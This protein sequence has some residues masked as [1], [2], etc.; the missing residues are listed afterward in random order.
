M[1]VQARYQ[2]SNTSLDA[3]DP[4]NFKKMLKKTGVTKE[5]VIEAATALKGLRKPLSQLSSLSA[6]EFT[7]S[8]LGQAL[9]TDP[10]WKYLTG[11]QSPNAKSAPREQDE[12][13]FFLLIFKFMK[14]DHT[15][16]MQ[17]QLA[18]MSSMVVQSHFLDQMT[19]QA[20]TNMQ[21]MDTDIKNA[22]AEKPSSWQSL[23][24][25]L[26]CV[27]GSIL[28][29]IVTV[30]LGS[31][32]SA[33]AE[34]AEATEAA[35]AAAETATEAGSGVAST[36]VNTAE[37]AGAEAEQLGQEAATNASQGA[38]KAAGWSA[39]TLS[40]LSKAAYIIG[41]A[42]SA[43]AMAA[44]GAITNNYQ[45]KSSQDAQI[46]TSKHQ[47]QMSIISS[48]MESMQGGIKQESSNQ[49]N[50]SSNEQADLSMMQQ[51]IQSQQQAFGLGKL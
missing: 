24:G 47:A 38:S 45:D 12:L 28:L 23:W 49:Q 50:F 21:D 40:R 3:L 51:M 1:A 18:S 13:N 44:D 39:T 11:A 32:L 29:S 22:L 17:S 46:A 37:Q 25:P 10:V 9:A 8:Q 35:T 7:Q 33:A 14:S 43:G 26:C 42:L 4:D 48:S 19:Q 30:G 6:E 34:A 27:I 41:G 20:A 36:A 2:D 5:Q 16:N 31:A 15:M